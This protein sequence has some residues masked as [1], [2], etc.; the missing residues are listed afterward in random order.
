MSRRLG[1]VSAKRGSTL[2]RRRFVAASV[3]CVLIAGLGVGCGS[4]GTDDAANGQGA[5]PSPAASLKMPWGTFKLSD[6]IRSQVASGK[7]LDIPEIG[8]AHV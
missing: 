3:A 4:A 5:T 8:R 7:K 6:Q 2:H 1:L